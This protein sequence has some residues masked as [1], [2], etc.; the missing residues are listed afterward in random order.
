ML[1]RYSVILGNSSSETIYGTNKSDYIY[2]YA[3]DDTVYGNE[4]DDTLDGG[5][6][7]D[8]LDG[9]SGDDKYIFG[10]Q[11]GSDTINQTNV[12]G[13]DKVIFEN[14]DMDAFNYAYS[15][16]D[17]VI[18]SKTTT[19][20]LL[21]KSFNTSI[22]QVDS[23]SFNGLEKVKSDIDQLIQAMATS[24]GG[25]VSGLNGGVDPIVP[26]DTDSSGIIPSTPAF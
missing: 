15:G 26:V 12:T 3:G 19:D 22:N 18:S 14:H 5:L 9:G 6:G 21:I 24:D 2:S 25:S 1:E 20:Q 17:L 7:N 16:D 13:S 11:F 8:I 23:F 4:D 10:N